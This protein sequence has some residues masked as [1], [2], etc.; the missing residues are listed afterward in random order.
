MDVRS[1]PLEGEWRIKFMLAGPA[2][3]AEGW[4]APFTLLP[5]PGPPKWISWSIG[6]SPLFALIAL[7][8]VGWRR[9]RPAGRTETYAW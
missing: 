3:Q 4:T 5:P 2:G 8:I 1:L 7:I 9:V 6:A